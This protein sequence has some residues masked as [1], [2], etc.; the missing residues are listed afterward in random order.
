MARR[1]GDGDIEALLAGF[2]RRRPPLPD[3]YRRIYEKQYA[4]NREGRGMAAALA[5]KAEAWM[6]RRVAAVPGTPALELGAGTLNHLAYEPADQAYDI[7]EPF[8]ALF[9]GRA[10]IDRVRRVYRRLDDVPGSERY[11]RILSIA[12]LEHMVEL[13]REL[14]LCG[15]LLAQ[16]GTFVAGIPSEG[17]WLWEAGWR[18][19]TG[20]A[21][22]LHTRLDYAVL[23]RHE[24]VNRAPE[25]IALVRHFFAEVTVER[26]PF[27]SHHLSLYALL[28]ARAPD[29]GRCEACLRRGARPW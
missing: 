17:G 13:P 15:R 6:H 19:T 25:I 11:A 23:M 7:V 24:H 1:A 4:A 28:T 21:F 16:G 2:P 18:C 9:A 26:F 14:A 10:E 12:V 29:L 27:P 5:Q 8:T 20:L 3:P 22:R